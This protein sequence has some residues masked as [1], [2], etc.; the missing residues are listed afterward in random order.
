MLGCMTTGTVTVSTPSALAVQ[1]IQPTDA[2]CFGVAD[3][4]IIVAVTGGTP[5][6]TYAWSGGLDPVPNP[7]NVPA[8]TYTLD[9]TDTDGC[10]ISTSAVVN[11][12]TAI[13]IT[14]AGVVA[15]TC[16][17]NNG[18]VDIEVAGG[19]PPYTYLWSGGEVVQ[20]PTNLPAGLTDVTITDGNGCMAMTQVAITEPGA[21]N[22]LPTVSSVSCFNASDGSIVINTTGG[23]GPYTYTWSVPGIGDTNTATNLAGGT[24]S[25][26]VR[27]DDGCIFPIA[28]VTVPEPDIISVDQISSVDATC[29]GDDGSVDLS[30]IGGTGTYT[31]SWTSSTGPF[32]AITED[33]SNLEPGD[34][35]LVVTD[36]NSCSISVQ[37]TIGIPTPPTSSAVATPTLC[38]G[39]ANG[40][41][42]VLGNGA[43]GGVSYSWDDGSIGDTPTPGGLLAGTYTVTITDDQNCTTT[44]MATVAEPPVLVA[45]SLDAVISCFGGDD[46]S[47]VV[48]V[49]GGTPG[50][51]YLWSSGDMIPDP[52]GLSA[53]TYSVVVTDANGCTEEATATIT[54]PALLEVAATSTNTRCS[55]EDN[56]TIVLA[57]TGGDGNYDY[58]WTDDQYDGLNDLANLPAGTYTVIVTDGKGCTETLT[59]QIVAPPAVDITV[60]AISDYAGFNVSCANLS[61]G[62][63]TVEGGGGNGAPFT[64]LWDDGTTSNSIEGLSAGDYTVVVTDLEGCTE[65]QA[66]SLVAPE[67]IELFAAGESTSCYGEDDGAVLINNVE[68]GSDPYRFSIDGSAFGDGFFTGLAAGNYE[69]VV[70]DANGCEEKQVISV[71][72]PVE[73]V[74]DLAIVDGDEEIQLGDSVYI[75]TVIPGS[76]VLD[77]FYWVLGREDLACDT[78]QGQW[79]VPTYTTTYS[80]FV[81]DENGCIDE[82][83]L[84]IR[85]KK[86]R[87]I[88]IPSGFSPVA[89]GANNT[90]TIY[91]GTGVEIVESFI[92]ADRWGEIVFSDANF[93]PNDPSHGWDGTLRGKVLNPGVFVYFAKVRFTDGRQEIFK[94]DVTLIK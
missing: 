9:I 18:S 74:A 44:A 5:G 82:D 43:N 52:S 84:Q 45:V 29:N 55:N 26:I 78:C 47:T 23:N 24:Y 39:D 63:A 19:T 86:D 91:G 87:L 8:G 41:I 14:V 88:Y 25:V 85:V 93:M 1:A 50:Y 64:Y 37:T 17:Q 10:V 90:F 94:G 77:T 40:S 83:E 32:T 16:N 28:S 54:E 31:Y 79:V 46:G 34:Y 80:I 48:T 27:D 76:V 61:D 72:E 12:P 21:L 2:S 6:Y 57:A 15:A 33:I 35:T 42:N 3:G 60:A 73:L 4:T 20:D 59:E 58:D 70:Q 56:G 68:G 69:I 62:S 92:V 11:E 22:A 51:S 30:F 13:D 7:T 75:T 71:P 49:T 65:I 67:A 38:N 89:T 36:A 66:I 53:G 81:E